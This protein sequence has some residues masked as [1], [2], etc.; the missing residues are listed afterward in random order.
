MYLGAELLAH[1]ATLILTFR[2]TAR[3]FSTAAAPSC[4]LSLI[5]ILASLDFLNNDKSFLTLPKMGGSPGL[6][7][8]LYNPRCHRSEQGRSGGFGSGVLDQR[9][10][11]LGLRRGAPGTG[12]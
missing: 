8:P 4:V 9:T 11:M 12:P 3:L 5:S 7:A 2:G 1:T 6:L 10:E